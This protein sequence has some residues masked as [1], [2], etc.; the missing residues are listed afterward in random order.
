METTNIR[1]TR[2]ELLKTKG[3][4]KLAKRGLDLL[5]LK[6]SS[7]IMEFF[8]ISKEVR[9]LRGNVRELIEKSVTSER[10][11]EIVS[12]KLIIENTAF[13]Q[14]SLQVQVNSKNVMGVKIP[15]VTMSK[16]KSFMDQLYEM[17]SL[18]TSLMETR[19]NFVELLNRLLVIAEKEI[20]MR[21]L[22][23]EIDRTKR[24][25]NSIENV[26]IPRLTETAT[27]IKMKL[28]EID[29]ETFITLKVIKGKIEERVEESV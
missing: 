12:G 11:A 21:R 19:E 18:P 24:R 7:L 5:K 14:P 13:F 15:Q 29:R 3:R 1:P 20:A 26:L 17:I 16:Q 27:Y 25:T 4:I 9:G 6:R 10:L 28:D 8:S 2:M 22:L 23:I